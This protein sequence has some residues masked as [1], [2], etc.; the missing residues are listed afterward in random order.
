[1]Q[2]RVGG[3]QREAQSFRQFDV[4]RIDESKPISARPCTR[5]KWSQRV[6]L[7]RRSGEISQHRVDLAG[8]QVACSVESAER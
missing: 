1:M 2:P 3:H 8:A 5:Q 4:K 7:D 6:A